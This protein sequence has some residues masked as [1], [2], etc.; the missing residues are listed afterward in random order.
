MKNVPFM[1]KGF[2]TLDSVLELVEFF[3]MLVQI[4]TQNSPTPIVAIATVKSKILA[5]LSLK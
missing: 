2:C 5:Q 1:I 4:L 3:R